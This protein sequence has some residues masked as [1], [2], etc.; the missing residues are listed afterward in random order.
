MDILPLVY[1][2]TRFNNRKVLWDNLEQISIT[3]TLLR[4]L[5]GDFNEITSATDKF[6]GNPINNNRANALLTYLK[7]L[8]WSIWGLWAP[9]LLSQ[10]LQLEIA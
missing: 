7:I 1:A 5:C 10:T 3:H 8:T 4:V 6:G 9:D 2:S